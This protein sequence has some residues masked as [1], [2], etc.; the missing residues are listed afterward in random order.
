MRSYTIESKDDGTRLSRYIEKVAPA[1]SAGGMYKAI[2]TKHIKLN[3]KRCDASDKLNTG[4]ILT[5]WLNDELIG[6]PKK[7][8]PDFMKASPRIDILYEDENIALIYKPVGINSHPVKG[9]YSDNLIARFLRHL[10]E[11]GEYDPDSSV[12]TPALCNRLDRNTEGIVIAGKSRAATEA[13]NRTIREDRLIKEYRAVTTGKIPEN[14]VY[15]AFLKKNQET[16][17][18]NISSRE[19][20]EYV[21]IR[22][23]IRLLR[24]S[25]GLNYWAVRLHTGRPHQIRAHMAYLGA[26]VLGDP[27]YG[28][29]KANA[30][31]GYKTQLLAAYS[32]SFGEDLPDLLSY[33]QGKV[34][35]LQ[36]EPFSEIVK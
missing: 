18:V 30:R 23:E 32:I 17:R 3:G 14:G 24:S 15:D 29:Q 8:E 11:I 31:Y 12:F 20:E 2:R 35:K 33:M 1:L 28:D 36:K 25:E 26:P 6:T 7:S 10:Y 16:N 34:V 5:I 19:R 27:K 22:T 4:D 9:D 21:P 13:V